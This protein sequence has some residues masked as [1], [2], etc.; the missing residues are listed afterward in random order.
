MITGQG[1]DFQLDTPNIKFTAEEASRLIFSASTSAYT[2]K[3]KLEQ[4]L[5]PSTAKVKRFV[6]LSVPLCN[7]A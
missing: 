3:T 4:F 7:L 2:P 1:H 6:R 5:P